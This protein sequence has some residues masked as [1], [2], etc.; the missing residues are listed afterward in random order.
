MMQ[1]T[2]TFTILCAIVVL[3]VSGIIVAG[4]GTSSAL[5]T[6]STPEFSVRYVDASYDVPPKYAINAYT[7]QNEMVEEGKHIQNQS[8][9]VS[10]KNQA[11]TSYSTGNENDSIVGLRYI[12]QVKGHF[13]DWYGEPNPID[14]MYR[15]DSQYTEKRYGLVGNNAS[16]WNGIEYGSL[17]VPAGG[18]VDVRV[19]A[20]IGYLT[21]IYGTPTP[22]DT[23]W[24]GDGKPP[25]HNIFT[26]ES[27]AWSSTQTIKI[28]TSNAGTSGSSSTTIKSPAPT[29]SNPP[30]QPTVTP[31]QQT[32]GTGVAFG[33]DFEQIAIIV[34]VCFVVGLVVVVAFQQRRLGKISAQLQ[35]RA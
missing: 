23:W 21:T 16:D 28:P 1:A 29:D 11:F 10:I 30:T 7:G 5:Q 20:Y 35:N 31:T 34:L 24:G 25:R 9:L 12:I 15:S 8:V 14:S 26:G 13:Q 32:T 33:F 6:P 17:D 27:S 22:Y 4:I 18:E 19:K 2:R 3:I